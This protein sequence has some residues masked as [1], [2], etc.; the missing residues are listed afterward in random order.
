MVDLIGRPGVLCQPDS[1]LNGNSSISVSS[2]LCHPRF[3]TVEGGENFKKM[4]ERYF[5]DS[6]SLDIQFDDA[7]SGNS[8]CLHSKQC[9]HL[10]FELDFTFELIGTPLGRR[11]C[12][13]VIRY[14][15][16]N[17]HNYAARRWL[18]MLLL[19]LV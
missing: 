3:R 9:G 7:S 17:V 16:T 1:M 11:M 13:N 2:P 18:Y 19:T 6:Q 4:A 8:L 15:C 5:S 10:T 14:A 12:V